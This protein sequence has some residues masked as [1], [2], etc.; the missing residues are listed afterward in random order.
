VTAGDQP[1]VAAAIQ[2][3]GAGLALPGDADMAATRAAAEK[4]V[5]NPAYRVEAQRRAKALANGQGAA[6]AAYAVETLLDAAGGVR[7][8]AV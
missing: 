2:E 5:M 1:F 4:V 3:F 7:L 8:A 6:A